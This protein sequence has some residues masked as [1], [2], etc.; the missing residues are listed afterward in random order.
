MPRP[1]PLRPRSF[2]G[3]CFKV[4]HDECSFGNMERME[5]RVTAK[6]LTESRMGKVCGWLL[7]LVWIVAMAATDSNAYSLW[8]FL[9]ALAVVALLAVSCMISGAKTVRIPVL[10]WASLGLCLYFLVRCLCSYSLVESWLESGLIVSAGVFYVAGIYAAQNR[11]DRG[12]VAVLALAVLLNVLFLAVKPGDINML[13]TGRPAVGLTGENNSPMTLFVYKNFA[14]SFLVIGGFALV[15]GSL[16]L[17][18]SG[19]ARGVC[20]VCG[21][22]GVAMSLLCESRAV[23]LLAPILMVAMSVLHLVVKLYTEGR[24]TKGGVIVCILTGTLIL[25]EMGSL[26]LGDGLQEIAGIDTH[27]R[28]DIWQCVFPVALK[29]PLWG[30]GTMASHWEIIG[31]FNEWSTPNM[32]HNEYLQV[33]ADYGL[34]GLVGVLLFLVF[35]TLN[36]LRALA[37]DAPDAGRR[38]RVAVSLLIVWGIAA[39]SVSDFPCHS[40]SLMGMAAFCCGILASPFP[41]PPFSLFSRRKWMRGRGPSDVPVMAQGAFG[42][43]MVALAALGVVGFAVWHYPHLHAAWMAQWRFDALSLPGA[44]PYVKERHAMMEKI[45][46]IYPDSAIADYYFLLPQYG[47]VRPGAEGVLRKALAANPR[48]GYTVTMLANILGRQGRYEEAEILMRRYY[49]QEGLPGS[50]TCNWPFYYYYNLLRW[51]HLCMVSGQQ[52]VGMSMAEYALNMGRR[53]SFS[54]SPELFYRA[55]K[56]WTATGG[57]HPVR[58]VT[59]VESVVAGKLRVLR[60]LGVQKDDSWMQPMEHGGKSALYPEWGLLKEKDSPKKQKS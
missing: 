13:W 35:H 28:Y 50:R 4:L 56:P 60:K 3:M 43:S 14:S 49:P 44:D 39:V 37:A 30:Y 19:R 2:R 9:I 26:F 42:K 53:A 32:A 12:V 40:F 11:S 52:E 24:V 34:I 48:Q 36:G 20:A 51:S 17:P 41:H 33:W 8:P 54:K 45:M 55:K 31:V 6:R 58:E 10:G 15:G 22:L 46:D 21:I 18:W 27:L 1:T 16:W 25:V 29:A 23:I 57:V 5:Q 47:G 7:G 59:G 38:A